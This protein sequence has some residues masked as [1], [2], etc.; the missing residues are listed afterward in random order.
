MVST[1]RFAILAVMPVAGCVSNAATP[2]FDSGPVTAAIYPTNGSS[3]IE[4]TYAHQLVV[5]LRADQG[6]ATMGDATATFDGVPIPIINAGELRDTVEGPTCSGIALLLTDPRTQPGQQVIVVRDAAH[7]WTIAATNMFG[8]T[9]ERTGELVPA[10]QVEVLWRDAEAVA[11][12]PN[13]YF[14]LTTAAGDLTWS[15]FFSGSHQAPVV[16]DPT[17]LAIDRNVL[18]VRLPAHFAPQSVLS[19]ET[20]RQLPIDACEGPSR[21]SGVAHAGL[22]YATP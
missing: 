18:R 14:E 15:T 8:A 20:E 19:F 1:R 12:A 6:C 5:A 21:C 13:S 16:D 22:D 3:R 11:T 2:L 7:T 9:F 17:S 4:Q 10:N